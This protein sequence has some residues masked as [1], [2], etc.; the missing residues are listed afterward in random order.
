[1]AVSSVIAVLA[2]VGFNFIFRIDFRVFL[3]SLGLGLIGVLVCRLLQAQIRLSWF[4]NS[5][6]VI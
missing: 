6:I 2:F 1:M 4:E 3:L 5:K